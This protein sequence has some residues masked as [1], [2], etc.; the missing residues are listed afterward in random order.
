MST[1]SPKGDL[2]YA[3]LAESK[4]LW[5]WV[6]LIMIVVNIVIVFWVISYITPKLNKVEPIF[7]QFSTS[8]D[9]YFEQ[10]PMRTLTKDQE[11]FLLKRFLRQY[12]DY[13]ETLDHED[14]SYFRAQNIIAMSDPLIVQFQQDKYQKAKNNFEEFIREI[15][16]VSDSSIEFIPVGSGGRGIHQIE[17]RATTKKKGTNYQDKRNFVATLKYRYSVDE[18]NETTALLNPMGIKITDYQI[19]ER[20]IEGDESLLLPPSNAQNPLDETFEEEL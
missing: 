14:L 17:F 16:I 20:K 5:Q 12:V 1:R 18:V 11:T 9:V 10:I 13:A 7:V 4:I 19:S 2:M 6:S 3:A 8:E 15:D